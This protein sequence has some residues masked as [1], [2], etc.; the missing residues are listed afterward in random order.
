MLDVNDDDSPIIDEEPPRKNDK[1]KF[2]F[3]LRLLW[4][5]FGLAI[6]LVQAKRITEFALAS[7]FKC[8]PGIKFE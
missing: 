8:K 6:V 5:L 2:R 3:Y 7:Y 1:S 4:I